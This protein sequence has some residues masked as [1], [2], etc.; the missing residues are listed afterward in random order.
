MSPLLLVVGLPSVCASPLALL[1]V[2]K[3]ILIEAHHDPSEVSTVSRCVEVSRSPE[4]RA[5]HPWVAITACKH[6]GLLTWYISA[7]VAEPELGNE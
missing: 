3:N 2:Y 4:D 6:S 1:T 7:V 5:S